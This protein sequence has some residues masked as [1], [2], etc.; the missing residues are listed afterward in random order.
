MLAAISS[1]Q[2][3]QP[4]LERQPASEQIGGGN[5]PKRRD[6]GFADACQGIGVGRRGRRARCANDQPRGCVVGSRLRHVGCGVNARRGGRQA[7]GD[8][9]S[10]KAA[11]RIGA[12]FGRRRQDLTLEFA[13]FLLL[14]YGW[15]SIFSSSI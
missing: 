1:H 3:P 12:G 10:G 11:Q 8:G 13:V 9:G 4:A 15:R 5:R 7:G 6:E 14:S 2:P